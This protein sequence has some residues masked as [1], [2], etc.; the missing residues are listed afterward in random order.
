MAT[1]S[2]Q[3]RF[4]DKDILWRVES[5]LCSKHFPAFRNL[6]IDV[7]NGIVTVSG[8]VDNFHE[9]Q[10]ALNSC[11]RVAGVLQL[12]DEIEVSVDIENQLENANALS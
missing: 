7:L 12:I 6:Q 1:T 9:R 5:Y 8:N 3:I 4:G 11:R 10:V 2:H